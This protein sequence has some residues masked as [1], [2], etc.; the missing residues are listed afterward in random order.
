MPTPL[1]SIGAGR[2]RLGGLINE[3]VSRPFFSTHHVP[4][5]VSVGC[6]T[7]YHRV[8]GLSSKNLFSH[9]PKGQKSIRVLAELLSLEAFLLGLKMAILFVYLCLDFSLNM[10]MSTLPHLINRI[11]V[12]VDSDP[13]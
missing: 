6:I 5:L 1:L 4:A 13:P 2:T 7:K 3:A 11:L 12:I 8:T 9:H 10:S